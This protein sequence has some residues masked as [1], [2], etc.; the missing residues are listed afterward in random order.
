MSQEQVKQSEVSFIQDSSELT[1]VELT[2]NQLPIVFAQSKKKMLLI[3]ILSLV[4][5]GLFLWFYLS[6]SD[7]P[8]AIAVVAGL[9]IVCGVIIGVASIGF[10]PPSLIIDQNGVHNTFLHRHKTVFVWKDV[11]SL[12]IFKLGM[13]KYIS[14]QYNKA[15]GKTRMP[16]GYMLPNTGYDV[17]FTV[18]ILEV[19]REHFSNENN[20][21]GE[22]Q[23]ISESKPTSETENISVGQNV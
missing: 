16:G 7:A 18:M 12:Y 17:N 19:L 13:T 4:I 3:A 22:N 6:L 2:L 10:P 21:M 15:S 20:L 9:L 11:E 1:Y 5:G 23:S 14:F 8:W